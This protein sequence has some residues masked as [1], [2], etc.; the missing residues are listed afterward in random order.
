MFPVVDAEH[1]NDDT[2]APVDPPV[3][4]LMANENAVPFVLDPPFQV[5]DSIVDD[6]AVAFVMPYAPSALFPAPEL[7]YPINVGPAGETLF[8]VSDPSCTST[9]P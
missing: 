6:P 3:T 1:V 8:S 7:A 5:M 4:S 2:S 9:D